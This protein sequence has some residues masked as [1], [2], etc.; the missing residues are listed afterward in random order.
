[1]SAEFVKHEFLGRISVKHHTATAFY[2]QKHADVYA[3]WANSHQ[4]NQFCI[5]FENLKMTRTNQID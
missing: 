4:Q 3:H 5:K 2:P 1:M